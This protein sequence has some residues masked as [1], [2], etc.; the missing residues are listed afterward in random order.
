MP[1]NLLLDVKHCEVY[2]WVAGYIKQKCPLHFNSIMFL[3]KPSFEATFL[4][5]SQQLDKVCS[6][7]PMI[8]LL[9]KARL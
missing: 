1:I 8:A 9:L 3:S 5:N 2:L 4:R 6:H 7:H